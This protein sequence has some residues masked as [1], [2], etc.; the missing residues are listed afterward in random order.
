M[1]TYVVTSDTNRVIDFLGVFKA[2]E[3]QVL[4]QTAADHFHQLKG[5]P[6]NQS[7]VPEG[8]QVVIYVTP[9]EGEALDVEDEE[10]FDHT[11]NTTDTNTTDTNTNTTDTNTTDPLVEPN[12]EPLQTTNTVEVVDA[13]SDEE[14]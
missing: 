3:Q 9:E 10:P 2:D 1:L 7:N 12:E 6:L 13:K 14:A 5:V 11:S 8:V 4:G